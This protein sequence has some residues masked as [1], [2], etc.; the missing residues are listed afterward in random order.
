MGALLRQ[1]DGTLMRLRGTNDEID[2]VA[3]LPAKAAARI[4]HV[5]KWRSSP[6]DAGQ[7]RL[8]LAFMP[9]RAAPMEVTTIERPLGRMAALLNAFWSACKSAFQSPA[10]LDLHPAQVEP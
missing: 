9:L 5:Q 3:F 4:A 6:G 10:D 2:N 1:G 7:L 8:R